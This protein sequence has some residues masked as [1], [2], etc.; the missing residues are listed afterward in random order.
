MRITASTRFLREVLEPHPRPVFVPTMGA[1]HAGHEALIH[2]AKEIAGGTRPVVVSVF[3]NPTQFN[4][5]S[6]FERYPRVVHDD[7]M[8]CEREGVSVFFTPESKEVYPDGVR[9]VR[10]DALPEVARLP[11]LEDAARPGHFAGVYAVVR[12]LFEMVEPSA[13][14]FGEKD[15]QQLQVVRALVAREEMN[16]EVVGVETVREDDG[17]AM[18]SRN[19]HLTLEERGFASAVPRALMLAGEASEP[20]SAERAASEAIEAFGLEVEYAAVRDAETLL[21]PVGGRP[22][23]V[24]VAARAGETRLIDNAPWPGWRFDA[25]G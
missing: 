7:A 13:A 21:T 1:L 22:A 15:W 16:V 24:L 2:R 20:A 11:K 25:T 19:T 12:R 10:E 3:V 6:D 18:S 5:P 4:E 14:V 9:G 23:R 8:V 17:L